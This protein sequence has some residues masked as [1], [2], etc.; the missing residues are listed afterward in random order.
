MAVSACHVTS[1]DDSGLVGRSSRSTD[2]AGGGPVAAP[3][4]ATSATVDSR[5]PSTSSS[6][7]TSASAYPNT[8]VAVTRAEAATARTCESDV[9]ASQ[10]V[11]R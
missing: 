9:P 7:L 4:S 6:A 3:P 8:S 1:A 11:C 10:K 2:G 5:V